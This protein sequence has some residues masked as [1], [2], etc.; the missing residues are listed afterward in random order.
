MR[1]IILSLVLLI[2]A[3]SYS[4]DTVPKEC[5]RGQATITDCSTAKGCTV[6]IHQCTDNTY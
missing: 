2:S 5:K 6:N 3:C 1:A 4:I